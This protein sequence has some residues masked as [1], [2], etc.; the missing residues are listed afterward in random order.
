MTILCLIVT[1]VY[2]SRADKT[3]KLDLT[4]SDLWRSPTHLIA[5]GLGLGLMRFAPGTWGTLGAVPL[6]W[7][8]QVMTPLNYMIITLCLFFL[9]VWVTGRSASLLGVP[10]YSGIVW[11]EV[12]GFLMT[13][14]LAPKGMVWV[15]VGFGLFRL[16]DIVKPYPIKYLEAAPGGWGIMLDDA[17]AAVYAALVLQG[18]AW[19]MR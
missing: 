6:Y 12:V 11:D 19:A 1:S 18:I 15:G 7:L 17:A 16:F 9:G 10:D 2:K 5:F 8:L 14:F 3:R 13:M 4:F